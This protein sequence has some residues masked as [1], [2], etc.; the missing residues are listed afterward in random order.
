M[1]KTAFLF[2][3]QGA[4]KIGMAKDIAAAFAGAARAFDIAS[5][6]AG[7][8]M[9]KMI[10]DGDADTLMK[11]ENTQPAVVTANA[12]CF[13]AAV[14]SKISFDA[15][16]GLSLGE[17]SALVAA[18]ALN[19]G[20]AVSLTKKRGKFMQEAVPE[21]VGAM[22]AIIGLSAEDVRLLVYDAGGLVEIANLNCPG[23]VV[24]S[25]IRADVERACALARERGAKQAVLLP[26]SAPFHSSLMRP[27]AE[28]FEAELAGVDIRELSRPVLSNVTAD[29][30]AHGADIAPLLLRQMYSPVRFEESIL[31]LIADGYDTFV[32]LGPGTALSGFVKRISKEARIFNIEDMPSLEKTL[33]GLEG[34]R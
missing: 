28:R 14:E 16:L 27:A 7:V 34:L 21:G 22:A 17:Y 8:D 3:G 2:A 5:E 12:A 20:G 4:Q 18:G 26:V 33:A 25:G 29:Y 15:A 31:R 13:A 9:R 11:T 10:F 1:S 24:I 23:Q 32:A 19:L 6:A 30:I